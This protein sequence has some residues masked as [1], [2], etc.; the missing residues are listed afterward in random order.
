MKQPRLRF[1]IKGLLVGLTVGIVV[2]SFRWLIEHGL[3]IFTTIYQHFSWPIAIGVLLI[4]LVIGVIISQLLKQEPNI[5]GSG[6]PQVEGQLQG[7]FELTWWSI[8]WRKFVGGVLALSP[9]LFLGREGP[10]I[11]LGA[12][13]GQGIS[14]WQHDDRS[15]RRIMIAA[16]AAAGLSAAFN[17][18]IAGSLFVVE[19]I[20]HNFSPLVWLS[21]LSSAI[22]ANFISLYV[23]G[24]LPVL[25]LIY[26]KPLPINLYWHLLI[27][28]IILGL[29]G[30]FYQWILLQLPEWYA[31]T[32]IPRNYQGLI[33]LVLVIPVGF[34]VPQLIGGG[35]QLI[36]NFGHQVPSFTILLGI[37]AIRFI[38]SMV[39][40]GSGLPGGI[41]LPILSLGAI[42]GAA[43]AQLM[44]GMH[45]LP[46]SYIINFIIFAMA[47]YFSAIGKAPFT[48][49]LL[50][51]EMVGNLK[52]LMPLA[53]V[54]LIAYLVLDSLNGAPIYE[55]LLAKLVKHPSP[56]PSQQMERIE[57][58]IFAGSALE[59]HQVRDITW[60]KSSL[61]IGI[62]RGEKE[63]IPHGDS[64]LQAGQTLVILTSATDRQRVRAQ[65][66]QLA[67][68]SGVTFGQ[69]EKPE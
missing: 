68:T 15:E 31:H 34:W 22:G 58:P 45:V 17:A 49:I 38:F 47:G 46:T 8:L 18:P 27:L 69:A 42:I 32:K 40:Y 53:V 67:T 14:E 56:A 6:I 41:F 59:D 61:L 11:Q 10:S 19:E 9:G 62:I 16:G 20:Y 12:A 5:S 43:Y 65:I 1:A 21:C 2:S 36:I 4:N 63:V 25:H 51:T 7:E 64:V 52:L 29:L 13:V 35:N 54:S 48:A 30:K 66:R 50:V 60:P 28:G 24:E 39:S 44:V 33:P 55:A 57:V 26:P 3:A 37:F 23:F